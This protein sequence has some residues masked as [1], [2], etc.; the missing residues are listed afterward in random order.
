MWSRAWW[1]VWLGSKIWGVWRRGRPRPLLCDVQASLGPGAAFVVTSPCTG[2]PC[3]RAAPS[4][5]TGGQGPGFLCPGCGP[6]TGK[7][8]CGAP[9]RTWWPVGARGAKGAREGVWGRQGCQEGRHGWPGCVGPCQGGPLRRPPVGG[10]R[11]RGPS[12]SRR[13]RAEFG[14]MGPSV[15]ACEKA[16]CG[17]PLVWG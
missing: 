17:R 3:G 1:G 7:G 13:D 2:V 6:F 14:G 12:S 16:P 10:S 5:S 4:E 9:E 15:E 11:R 8:G